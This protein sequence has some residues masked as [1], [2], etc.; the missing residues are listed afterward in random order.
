MSR[1]I[2][3]VTDTV[4]E[5]SIA[6]TVDEDLG[7]AFGSGVAG[8][9]T[10]V[11][12]LDDIRSSLPDPDVTGP[13]ALYGIAMD[14]ARVHDRPVLDEVRLLFGI[15]AFAAGTIGDTPV[16]SQGH[17]H[18]VTPRSGWSPPEVFQIWRGSAVILMQESAQ[19]DPARCY[20]IYAG[21]G[22]IVVTPPGWAHATI[23]ADPS[24][25]LVFGAW[26]DRD[27]TGFE[28]ADVRRHRGLAWIPT[29]GDDGALIWHANPA[30]VRRPLEER[31]P[32]ET[33]GFQV[34]RC[35][36]RQAVER[37]EVGVCVPHPDRCEAVWQGFEP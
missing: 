25:P 18:A 11:R 32:Q 12:H 27:Y 15:V 13:D 22:D 26:C 4:F 14:V 37:P 6:V 2:H 24:R 20:A 3:R 8:P 9:D 5:P 31:G 16:R 35:I 36:Y 34:G 17:V 10:E 23:N 29:V 19:D 30:Y 33:L 7:L 1:R 21:P 28:Y